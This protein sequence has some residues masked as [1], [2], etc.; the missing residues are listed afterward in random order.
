M[1][2]SN[3]NIIEKTLVVEGGYVNDPLDRG[4]E[5]YKGISRKFHGN[6]EGWEIIDD[7]RMSGS[8]AQLD[9]DEDLQEMVFEFYEQNY[10]RPFL[11]I[12]EDEIR[13]ELFDTAV[14]MGLGTATRFLQRALNLVNRNGKNFDDLVVDGN[15]GKMTMSAYSKVNKKILLKVLNGLQFCRYKDIVENDPTQEKFFNGWM[16]R[17]N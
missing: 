1:L 9:K 17:V 11:E 15:I 8:I 12:P 13:E 14:N 3:K 16:L 7:Y 2:Q 6:W 10:M 4:G 5:T